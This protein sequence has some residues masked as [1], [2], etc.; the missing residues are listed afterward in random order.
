MVEVLVW[1][2]DQKRARFAVS[3]AG[4]CIISSLGVKVCHKLITSW[5][6]ITLTVSGDNDI[7]FHCISMKEIMA[8]YRDNVV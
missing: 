1:L 8:D 7:L 2:A 4:L 3:F 5:P 6:I